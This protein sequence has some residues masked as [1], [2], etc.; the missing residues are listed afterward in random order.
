M[1][2]DEGL[3]QRV[4]ELLEEEHGFDEK[5]MFGGIGFLIYGNMACGIIGDDLIVR[6]GT[7]NY[8]DLLRLPHVRKFDLTGRAMRGWLMISPEGCET[9]EDL[10]G[11]IDR[12]LDFALSLP[13]K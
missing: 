10:S 1:A 11:W 5:R 13:P 12:C 6:V 7:E 3:A 8:E 2:Y 9:D 4:R